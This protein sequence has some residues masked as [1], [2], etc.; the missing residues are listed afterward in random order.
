MNIIPKIVS[1]SRMIKLSHTIFAL[2][3]ALSAAILAHRVT[4][5]TSQK[6][7]WIIIAMFGARSAAMGFNRLADASVD[8]ENPR[9]AV[10]E[11]PRGVI[12]KADASIFV[13]LSALLFMIAAANLSSLCFLLSFPV[14]AVLCFYSY[15]KRFTWLT[16]IILG[17]SIGLAPL[18]VWIAVNGDVSWKIG[19]L[20]MALL[21]YIAGFDILYACQDVEFDRKESLYSIPARFGVVSAMRISSCLHVLSAVCLASLYWLFS[22]SP[23]YLV[24][25]GIIAGL[26]ILEHTLVDPHD[27]T[28]IDIAFF[29]VNSVISIL[30]LAAVL[31]GEMLRGMV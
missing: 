27:L 7:F 2:P 10:R 30:V 20:S 25:V 12:S 24:I 6:L 4:P 17:F 21:T 15:A 14:L 9:T 1:Y 28:R 29:H 26:F 18:A 13:V 3:F 16:H 31:S 19:I 8:A 22:L 11:I 23:V 5:V